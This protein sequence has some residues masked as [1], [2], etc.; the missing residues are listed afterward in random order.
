[1]TGVMKE[2]IMMTEKIIMTEETVVSDGDNIMAPLSCMR[3]S[4]ARPIVIC[5]EPAARCGHGQ[6]EETNT[7]LALYTYCSL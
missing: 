1:M 7:L 4:H 5:Y 2:M 3:T 6:D